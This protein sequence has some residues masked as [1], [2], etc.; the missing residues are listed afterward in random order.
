MFSFRISKRPAALVTAAMVLAACGGTTPAAGSSVSATPGARGVGDPLF[1]YLGN[2]GYDVGSYDV[3]YDYRSGTTKMDAS[4][5]IA[6]TTTQALS[7]FSLDAAVERVDRVTVDGR[8]ARFRVSGQKLLI[9]PA[10]ELPRG[11]RF[12][13][14][15][16]FRVDRTANPQSPAFPSD[17]KPHRAAWVAQKDGFALLGQ[18]DRTHLFFP[19]N[20][21]P[22]DKA[23]VTFRITTP[24]GLRA[25]ANGTLRSR[26]EKA[27]RVTYVFATRD[28]IPTHVVQAAVGH[29]TAFQAKG[30]RGLPLRSYVA[31][32]QAA[33]A[34]PFVEGIAEQVVWME[35][36][37]G[38]YPFET[39]GVLGMP[40]GYEGVALEA[41]TISTYAAESLTGTDEQGHVTQEEVQN[42]KVTMM[43][44]LAHQYFG[45]A[46]AVRDWNQ[47]WISEGHAEFYQVLYAVE[48]GWRDLDDPARGLRARY[49]FDGDKRV[50]SGPPGNM[51]H[52]RDVLVGTNTAGLLML[53]GLRELVG[54]DTFRRIEKTFF[55]EYRGRSASTPDYIKV[56]NRVSGKDL[57]RY[58][59]GWIYDATTPP[60][61]GH[62]D[63]RP[64]G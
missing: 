53:F 41:A 18:P 57:T 23:K 54:P 43:H 46:V 31:T 45:D 16:S 3:S 58:I 8:A 17:E 64:R 42:D 6:A 19:C 21:H 38:P 10:R 62:P 60:M 36:Q 14:A 24:K 40:D 1:A 29:F 35:K 11:R 32:A 61:P 4:V 52:A 9:T 51:K 28:P 2:G 48:Q 49:D 20:D 13:V 30:P 39:Y 33:K 47:M 7:E 5:R 37:V 25:V 22:S 50:E 12:R 56:A 59:N 44:E 34:R 27:G 26:H 55:A 15:V 63:W